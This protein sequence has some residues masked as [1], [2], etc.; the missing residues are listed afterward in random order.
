MYGPNHNRA[1]VDK[2][3]EPFNV[4]G[5]LGE[6]ELVVRW[7][8]ENKD[9]LVVCTIIKKDSSWMLNGP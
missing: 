9:S 2:R 3:D 5:T 1:H 4:L 8:F 7:T 6:Q